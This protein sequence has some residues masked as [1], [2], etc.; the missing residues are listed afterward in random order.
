M[1]MLILL[2][3]SPP[4]P[5]QVAMCI[6]NIA[7]QG[8][9]WPDEFGS[10]GLPSDAKDLFSFSD[11]YPKVF[12][13]NSPADE[14]AKGPQVRAAGCAECPASRGHKAAQAVP[15]EARQTPRPCP[16]PRAS[17]PHRLLPPTPPT[18]P[19]R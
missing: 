18:L 19:R 5:L 12:D 16:L 15:P 8:R 3:P 10:L 2:H 7:F 9:F 4:P 11:G 13:A 14:A 1:C 17:S 6:H